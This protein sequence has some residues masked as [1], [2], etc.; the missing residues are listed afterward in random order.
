[1]ARLPRLAVAGQAHLVTL[2]G[3]P[4]V[5][6]YVDDAD[7]RALLDALR[8]AA[9]QHQVAVHAHVLAD[10]HLHLLVTPP[11]AAALGALM[12]ALFGRTQCGF[13]LRQALLPCLELG[14]A[15]P[16]AEQHGVAAHPPGRVERHVRSQGRWRDRGRPSPS[17]RTRQ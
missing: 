15:V 13:P 11:T 1:M 5:P 2:A 10:D 17:A 7:R 8:E 4:G 3:A 9:L 16:Q 12:Q 6:V 14:S